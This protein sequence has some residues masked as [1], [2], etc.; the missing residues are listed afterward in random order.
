MAGTGSSTNPAPVV[1]P[2]AGRAT[3]PARW[4]G[5]PLVTF[6]YRPQPGTRGPDGRPPADPSLVDARASRVRDAAAGEGVLRASGRSLDDAVHAAQA[7]ARV[8][9]APT[10]DAH[11]IL[12]A[13]DGELYLTR[14]LAHSYGRDGFPAIDGP[15]LHHVIREVGIA[16]HQ[17]EVLAVV[18]G[19]RVIDLRTPAP[20][21]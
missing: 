17:P 9:G 6:R 1:I 10:W 14:L 2:G 4:I 13:A 18:G 21:A 3:T 8:D 7:L 5:E 15:L 16:T 12:Q 20:G 19:K 11:A